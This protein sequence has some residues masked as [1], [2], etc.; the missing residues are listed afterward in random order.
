[1]TLRRGKSVH[2][3]YPADRNL[4]FVLKPLERQR[5]GRGAASPPHPQN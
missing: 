2:H 5:K 1:M 3:K 4:S